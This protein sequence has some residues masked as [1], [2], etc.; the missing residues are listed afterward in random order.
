M[1]IRSVWLAAPLVLLAIGCRG[2]DGREGG[3]T[4]LEERSES[5]TPEPQVVSL[6]EYAGSGVGGEIRVDRREDRLELAVLVRNARA[7]ATLPVRL[8]AGSCEALDLAFADLEAV[9]TDELGA[10]ESRSELSP[11]EHPELREP[12]AV[13]VHVHDEEALPIACAEL[14]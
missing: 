2:P 3:A 4:S 7:G 5:P 9:S 14:P 10:G 1:E 11:N 6:Q 12:T 8:H 13:A